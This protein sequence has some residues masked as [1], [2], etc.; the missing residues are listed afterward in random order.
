MKS[1]TGVLRINIRAEA[2]FARYDSLEMYRKPLGR[3]SA[4]IPEASI[5]GDRIPIPNILSMVISAILTAG[6]LR[7]R[8]LCL[9]LPH[10]API[11]PPA[12]LDWQ[13]PIFSLRNS[14]YKYIQT[15]RVDYLSLDP[16]QLPIHSCRVAPAQLDHAVNS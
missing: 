13:I 15:A 16:A 1:E 5:H 9:S 11:P 3:K 7:D 12:L 14:R 6:F 4:L 8:A 2:Y 10:F